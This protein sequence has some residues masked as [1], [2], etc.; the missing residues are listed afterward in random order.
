MSLD[1]TSSS[2]SSTEDLFWPTRTLLSDLKANGFA[3]SNLTTQ[4]LAKLETEGKLIKIIDPNKFGLVGK[5]YV[6]ILN[7]DPTTVFRVQMK[8]YDTHSGVFNYYINSPNTIN[9]SQTTPIVSSEIKNN[10]VTVWEVP[11]SARNVGF[12][13]NEYGGRRKSKRSK[14]SRRTKRSKKQRKSRRIRR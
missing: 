6:A 3:T 10:T 11:K 4:I 1:N 8:M 13:P 2:S 7:S 12:G 9:G 5:E 14:R